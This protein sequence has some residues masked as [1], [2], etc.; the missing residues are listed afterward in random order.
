[1]ASSKKTYSLSFSLTSFSKDGKRGSRRYQSQAV[2]DSIDLEKKFV[3]FSKSVQS[4]FFK[5]ASEVVLQK[6][7]S[8]L[9]GNARRVYEKSIRVA[10]IFFQRVVA[11]TPV[12][13]NYTVAIVNNK[14]GEYLK[15]WKDSNCVKNSWKLI[16]KK[17]IFSI[18][19]FSGCKFETVGDENDIDI[20]Y[21]TILNAIGSSSTNIPKFYLTN[22]N[23]HFDILEYGKYKRSRGRMDVDDGNHD[24][25]HGVVDGYSL[26][27]PAGM[28]RL[29]LAE[30]PQIVEEAQ[31]FRGNL[32]KFYAITSLERFD[33][34]AK[35][36]HFTM[37]LDKAHRLVRKSFSADQIIS[38]MEKNGFKI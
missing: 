6:S 22:T 10:A 2:R 17:Q 11:R 12:D 36:L 29:S 19:N 9:V 38:A 23:D 34:I 35:D 25:V 1:M 26:Q 20:I 27:A 33:H 16:I 4:D 5:K 31:H 14:T 37:A 7:I 24:R 32:N 3:A 15:H 18:A 13:E 28:Y 8:G 21:K 30:M